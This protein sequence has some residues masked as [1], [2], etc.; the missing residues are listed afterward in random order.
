[1]QLP[2]A[3]LATFAAI[4]VSC[5]S[6]PET[7]QAVDGQVGA[8]ENPLLAAGRFDS[9]V[10]WI[11]LSRLTDQRTQDEC[12]Q[13]LDG[14]LYVQDQN[15]VL[16]AIDVNT[17]THDWVLDIGEKLDYPLGPGQTGITAVTGDELVV[18]NKK[19]G[20]RLTSRRELDLAFWPWGQA[21][22]MGGTYYVG[23]AAPP[24]LQS[25]DATGSRAGWHYTTRAPVR[26]VIADPVRSQLIGLAEDGLVFAVPALPASVQAPGEENW[27]MRAPTTTF[28]TDACLVGDRLY[29]GADDSFLYCID[30]RNG[31]VQWKV[32]CEGAV[33]DV[34]LV[35]GDVVFVSSEGGLGAI[36]REAGTLLWQCPESNRCMTRIDDRCYVE[37]KAG[38]VAV[39]NVMDGTVVASFPGF[40]HMPAVQ[41]GGVFVAG[42]GEGNL[43]ALR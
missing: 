11:D 32:G 3:S 17:G 37:T 2:R 38:D 29:V 22:E 31:A 20:V 16:H 12:M 18:V 7:Q 33:T 10:W 5:S 41:G 1:M 4:F 43:I 40:H 25:V 19:T 9:E 15:A 14:H 28:S 8:S 6:T 35:V 36:S 42:D 23:R 30:A 27:F 26:Q 39:R 21:A 13:V 34:P 24:G